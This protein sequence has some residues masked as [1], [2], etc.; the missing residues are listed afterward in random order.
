MVRNLIGSVNLGVIIDSKPDCIK[1]VHFLK[2][3]LG[4]KI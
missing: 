2:I 4:R 1:E 3:N